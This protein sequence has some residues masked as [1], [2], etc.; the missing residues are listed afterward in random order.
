[1]IDLPPVTIE[2]FDQIIQNMS[3]EDR[4]WLEE[5]IVLKFSERLLQLVKQQAILDNKT[6]QEWIREACVSYA[7]HRNAVRRER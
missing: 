5:M 6:V 1:M 3:D 2:V 4:Q 7:H